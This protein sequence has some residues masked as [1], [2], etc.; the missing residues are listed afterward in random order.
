MDIREE[1]VALYVFRVFMGNLVAHWDQQFA[2]VLKREDGVEQAG[3]RQIFVQ[4]LARV[5]LLFK[6]A[7]VA[8]LVEQ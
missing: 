5:L 8:V 3:V 2:A 7:L 6:A 1:M 4:P